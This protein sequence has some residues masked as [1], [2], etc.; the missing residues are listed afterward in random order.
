MEKA[1]KRK[2]HF[3]CL[4]KDKSVFKNEDPTKFYTNS[5]EIFNSITHGLGS[6]GAIV[7]TT[8]LL[9]NSIMFANLTAVAVSLVYGV[10]LFI[11][12]TMSTL[13]HAFTNQKLKKVFRIFDHT[14]IYLLIAGSY[15]PISVIALGHTSKG[16]ILCIAVWIM[17]I[18]GI[19]L[20]SVSLKKFKIITMSLYV[21][22]GWTVVFAFSDIVEALPTPAFWL[23]LIGGICY[24]GGIIFYAQKSIK[25]MHGIWHLFVLAGSVLQF[26]CIF[27]YILPMSYI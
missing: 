6:F 25:F 20:S 13:Y 16:A 26:F 19:V 14:S 23:L 2:G 9:V 21:L 22:M 11:M 18:L 12:Y 17:A 7:G 3:M 27:L 1:I 4:K 5:E 10:S 15:T 24:T 8:L